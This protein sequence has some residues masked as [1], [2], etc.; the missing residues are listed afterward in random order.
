[1]PVLM[2]HLRQLRVQVGDVHDLVLGLLLLQLLPGEGKE[3]PGK[4]QAKIEKKKYG[5]G[6]NTCI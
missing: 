2:I 4:T 6:A 3:K 1:M 5:S